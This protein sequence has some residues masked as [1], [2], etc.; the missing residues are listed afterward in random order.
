MALHS[1]PSSICTFSQE[2]CTEET[3]KVMSSGPKFEYL[4]REEKK[5][6]PIKVPATDR[7]P[8]SP[9]GPDAPHKGVSLPAT[10]GGPC[11]W[12]TALGDTAN[13]AG[14]SLF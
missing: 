7:L 9:L 3:C 6:K 8:D 5:K 11:G 10:C 12:L 1:H 2:F 14:S 4:W 13:L